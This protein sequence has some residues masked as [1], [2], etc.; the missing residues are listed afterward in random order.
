MDARRRHPLVPYVV[1]PLLLLA[2]P[3]SYA[4]MFRLACGRDEK[5][6]PMGGPLG[7]YRPIDW[8]IDHTL[9]TQPLLTWAQ[10]CGVEPEFS[11]AREMRTTQF[12]IDLDI[13]FRSGSFDARGIFAPHW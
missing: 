5:A 12:K 1:V 4:P 9:L 6:L 2:Y 7:I 13:P 11:T 8:M 3:L 10:V